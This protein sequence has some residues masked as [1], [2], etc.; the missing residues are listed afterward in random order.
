MTRSA[1]SERGN[2][3]RLAF[4]S[5]LIVCILVLGVYFAG[6]ADRQL[7]TATSNSPALARNRSVEIGGI[8]RPASDLK[9]SS[10]TRSSL[11]DTDISTMTLEERKKVGRE[12]FGSTPHHEPDE[13][14]AIR[15]T[16]D[17][18]IAGPTTLNPE[19][20]SPLLPAVSFDPVTYK[21]NPSIYLQEFQPGRVWQAA[22]PDDGVPVLKRIGERNVT[23]RQGES[24]RLKVKSSPGAPVSFLSFDSGQFENGLTGISVAANADGVAEAVF[25]AT[26]GTI[27]KL[28]VLAASPMASGRVQFRMFVLPPTGQSL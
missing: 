26:P 14:L 10:S 16:Y 19:R 7:E 24:V 27:A 2:P 15:A 9:R 12:G 17:A 25:T 18:V 4:G 28:S 1:D 8:R 5:G 20:I 3:S 21:E 6:P 22:Q 23:L 13:S 11:K